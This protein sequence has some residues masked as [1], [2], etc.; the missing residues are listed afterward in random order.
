MK[1]LIRAGLAA[2]LLAASTST[3]AL[4]SL[5]SDVGT[6]SAELSSDADAANYAKYFNVTID[7]ARDRLELQALAGQL[8]E[9]LLKLS[10][11]TFGGLW[12]TN[13]PEF[14]VTAAFTDSGPSSLGSI[15]DAR[16][17]KYL[18]TQ[19]VAWSLADLLATMQRYAPLADATFD[20]AIDVA[21]NRVVIYTQDVISLNAAVGDRR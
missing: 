1:D 11:E 9:Q 18:H 16:L 6:I 17:A 3:A 20:A 4:A 15:V 8:Q 7:E 5:D 21:S 2:A 12:V 19:R 10:P 13:A 14:S